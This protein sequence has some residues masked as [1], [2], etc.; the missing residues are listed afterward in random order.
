LKRKLTNKLKFDVI[1]LIVILLL[2]V[3]GTV[4]IYSASSYKA[5]T[6]DKINNSQH[7]L[8]KQLFR[9]GLGLILMILFINIDYQLLQ[10]FAPIILAIS[11][12]L[13][14]Y[15]LV[16]GITLN[17]SKR[18]IMINGIFFQPS[19]LAKYALLLFLSVFLVEKGKKLQNLNEGLLPTLAMVGL[20]VLPIVLEPDLGTAVIVFILSLLLI[21][22]A[23][24]RVYHLS[25]LV[26]VGI[27]AASIVVKI[28]PYQLIRIKN[29]VNAVRG[30]SD[31]PYQVLQSLISFGNGGIAGIGLGNSRQK[32]H[33]L[34]QPFTD[35]IYSIIGEE[36]G[37]IGCLIVLIL[38]LGFLWRGLWIT[39]HAPDRKGQLLA[40]GI[41]GSIL[42]YAFINIG[43]SLNLLPVT[44]ITL[45]F[46][47]YGGSSLIMNLIAVGILLNIS[48]QINQGL[49]KGSYGNKTNIKVTSRSRIQKRKK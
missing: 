38:F 33:H 24:A 6:D 8:N 18:S 49:S 7:Y 30:I 10:K 15:V 48:K 45:S 21:F 23:G 13:L 34:P 14:L 32:M 42:L 2:V 40:V 26:A 5:K 31:P 1:L 46:I 27:V 4:A 44:G 47:S 20:I 11:F 9:L 3:I 36:T 37:L 43:I 39:I 16:G 29:Y 28:F 35:F 22:L 17:G 41:T 25:G 12:I 19:E